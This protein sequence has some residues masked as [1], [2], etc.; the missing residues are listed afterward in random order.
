MF[1]GDKIR[2]LVPKAPYGLIYDQT[3]DNVSYFESNSYLQCLPFSAQVNYLLIYLIIFVCRWR[4]RIVSSAQFEAM[5]N[6]TMEG[7]L[8]SHKEEKYIPHPLKLKVKNSYN[9]PIFSYTLSF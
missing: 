6:V 7:S 5:T 4:F 8:F 3:H 1:I 2:E 9:F